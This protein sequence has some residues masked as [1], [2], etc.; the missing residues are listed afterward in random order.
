MPMEGNKGLVFHLLDYP[1][2]HCQGAKPC[3]AGS[4]VAVTLDGVSWQ[5]TGDRI[6]FL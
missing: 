6:G 2:L 5:K 1:S 4:G 3:A